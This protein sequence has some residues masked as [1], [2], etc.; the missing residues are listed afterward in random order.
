M[1]KLLFLCLALLSLLA[2]CASSMYGV[3][4]ETWDRMSESERI[5][6]IRVYERQQ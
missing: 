1:K 5:E 3:P 2:A 6:A 4:Q